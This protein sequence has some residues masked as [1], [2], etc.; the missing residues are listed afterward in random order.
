MQSN[1]RFSSLARLY[2]D[3]AL[4]ALAN[5]RIF[6]AGIGGV[7]AWAA[8]ALA[9]SGVGQLV[10]VDM[11]HVAESNIN[12]QVH[13]LDSTLGQA[14]VQA[15]AERI[16]QINPLAQL[17]LLDDFIDPDN[18]LPLLQQY[19][20]HYVLDCTDNVP[21]K[22]ALV[23]ACRQLRIPLLMSG[24][25]GGKTNALALRGSDLSQVKYD[26]LLARVR[27]QLRKV[28]G[29]AS[30][31][32]A[33]GRALAVA[34]SMGVRCYWVDSPTQL[35]SAWQSEQ[36][37]TGAPLACAGYG[38]SV[39]VTASMGLAMAGGVLDALAVGR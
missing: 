4:V 26:K 18:A 20:P 2:G 17:Q 7:G 11:D 19:Q 12:R 37:P 1:R 34:P 36:A 8:E 33:K 24:G 9:R 15:M 32:D 25:A 13:A 16:A 14:K 10:L 3:N 6:I 29:F 21:A 28:H 27:Q 35:P 23:L 31:A 38:S 39:V 30:G 5:C 22:V